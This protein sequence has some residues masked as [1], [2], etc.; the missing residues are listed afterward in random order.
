MYREYMEET[1]SSLLKIDS[2]SGFTHEVVAMAEK[3]AGEMGYETKR[4]RRGGLCITVEGRDCSKSV[5]CFAHVDT[6]GLILRDVTENGELMVSKIGGPVL[7]SVEG[8]YCRIH[9]RSGK[10]Y[11]GT[12]LSLS[13]S[14]HVFSDSGTR[15]R[16]EENM[17]VRLDEPVFSKEDVWAL[18]IDR[19]DVIAVDPKLVITESGYIK[20]RYLDDKASA[21]MLLTVLKKMKTEKLMPRYRTYIVLTEYEEVG[22]GGAWQP[23]G[24]EEFLIVDMGC[25]GPGLGCTEQQVSIC[26][27]DS[28]GPYDYEM[29]S[30]LVS[31][32]REKGIDYAVDVYPHYSSDAAVAWKSGCDAPGALIGTGVHA[33]HGMERTHRDGMKNTF[34]LICAYLDLA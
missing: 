14:S 25:V 28:S 17:Y 7:P 4:K 24:I 8:E 34:E 31:L 18:G 23:E 9:T 2:P 22:S 10:V 1:L 32:S 33:S 6:V 12:V 20:S 29:V 15:I 3:I 21:A 27:K 30:R 26:A 16:D 11:T 13:P 19:G 5:A